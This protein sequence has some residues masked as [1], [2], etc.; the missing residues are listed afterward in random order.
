MG[1][2]KP[3]WASGL[4]DHPLS[5]Y[6]DVIVRVLEEEPEETPAPP[7]S[8][9]PQPSR[10][11]RLL[12]KLGAALAVAVLVMVLDSPGALTVQDVPSYWGE[13]PMNCHTVRLEEDDASAEWFWCRAAGGRPLPPG[14]YESPESQWTS[15]IT[16]REAKVSRI[17]ISRDGEVAGWAGY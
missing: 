1:R 11:P 3:L 17:R 16:R 7:P 6:D 2:D 15:D 4:A 10:P 14:L 13:I 9:A 12:P 8:P 5:N